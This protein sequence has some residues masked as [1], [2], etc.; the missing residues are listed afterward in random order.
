VV[1]A[2][3]GWYGV[4]DMGG[5]GCGEF[6]TVLQNLDDQTEYSVLRDAFGVSRVLP[7]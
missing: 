4:G 5:D 1:P 2:S 7:A 6:G 3:V